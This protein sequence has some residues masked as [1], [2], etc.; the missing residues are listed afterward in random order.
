LRSRSDTIR[1]VTA[2][3][4]LAGIVRGRLDRSVIGSPAAY[5]AAHRL[6]VV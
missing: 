4:V 2:G 6:T 1:F 5:R 3:Q